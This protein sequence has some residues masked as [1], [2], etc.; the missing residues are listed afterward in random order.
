MFGYEILRNKIYELCTKEIIEASKKY[1]VNSLEF[2]IRL[3]I[4]D[5]IQK[6]RFSY[7]LM[8]KMLSKATQGKLLE[9]MYSAYMKDGINRCSVPAFIEEKIKIKNI[10]KWVDKIIYF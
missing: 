2:N 1:R 7:L 10:I 5:C 6:S 9:V 3:Q 4:F 8:E